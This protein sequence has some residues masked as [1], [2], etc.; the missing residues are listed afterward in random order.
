MIEYRKRMCFQTCKQWDLHKQYFMR[1][2]EL[3]LVIFFCFEGMRICK[4]VKQSKYSIYYNS[5]N[6]PWD[7]VRHGACTR[8]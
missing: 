6:F 4:K 3:S 1:I 8:G 2:E 5:H 7:T